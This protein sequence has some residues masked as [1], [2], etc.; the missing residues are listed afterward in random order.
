MAAQAAE[1]SVGGQISRALVVT[2]SDNS[3]NATEVKDW[4]GG[5]SRVNFT[6]SRK[7][8][9]DGASG[10]AVLEEVGAFLEVAENFD[11]LRHSNVFFE[12]GFGKIRLGLASEA[13]DSRAYSDKSGAP[14]AH[15]Q[16]TGE[17]ETGDY[18]G[19]ISGGRNE[20][21]HYSSP[22]FRDINL[23]ASVGNDDRWS[24]SAVLD[25]EAT[26]G[27]HA[28]RGEAGYLDY[29]KDSTSIGASLGAKLAGGITF[30]AAWAKATNEKPAT[31]AAGAPDPHDPGYFQATVGYV[32]GETSFAVTWYRSSDFVNDGSEGNIVG[33]GFNHNLP[34]ANARLFASA[35]QYKAE[36]TVDSLDAKDTVFVVGSQVKF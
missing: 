1:V 19:G 36:D 15:G 9:D 18:F 17:I 24:V 12:G 23:E 7:I 4:G 22:S 34:K 21:V 28:V 26:A 13:A 8:M 27:G 14:V 31:A 25:I 2:D 32:L 16:E 33:V 20:G 30:S 29:G 6:V 5:G 3:D 35:Q 11:T 10:G